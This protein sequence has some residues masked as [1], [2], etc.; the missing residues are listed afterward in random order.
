MLGRKYHEP[1]F[2]DLDALNGPLILDITLTV[3]DSNLNRI[4]SY[5]F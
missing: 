3:S 1:K 5:R 2:D 4:K